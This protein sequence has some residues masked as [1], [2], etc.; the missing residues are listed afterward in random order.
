MDLMEMD[1]SGPG[2]RPAQGTAFSVLNLGILLPLSCRSIFSSTIQPYFFTFCSEFSIFEITFRF[3]LKTSINR[4]F[5][6]FKHF[7]SS[8][9]DMFK[10]Q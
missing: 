5:L 10:Y 4:N 8:N 7:H 1:G 2:T 6:V 9:I 3:R